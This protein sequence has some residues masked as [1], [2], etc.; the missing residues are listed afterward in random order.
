M[1]DKFRTRYGSADFV[2]ACLIN[3]GVGMI[4][5]TYLDNTSDVN[6]DIIIG[7]NDII[8]WIITLSTG[9]GD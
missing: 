1:T 4:E 9:P 7:L 6:E 2:G 3:E 8:L 5:G